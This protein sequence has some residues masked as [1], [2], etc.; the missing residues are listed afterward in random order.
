MSSISSLD[1]K[2][3]D[4]VGESSIKINEN[5]KLNYNFL[6][7]QNYQ[8]FNY[9]EISTEV[10]FDVF[11]IELNYIEER[12]H[13]GNANYASA[14]LNYSINESSKFNIV[15]KRNLVS[16]SSEYYDLSYQYFNDCL[17]AGLVFRREFYQDSELEP[18]DSLMFRISIFPDTSDKDQLLN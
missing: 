16:N 4:L 14:E 18:E 1:E 9:N 8:D 17:K 2:I 7:D 11:N 5:L 6:I 12:K 3:S 15:S 10:D 13:V